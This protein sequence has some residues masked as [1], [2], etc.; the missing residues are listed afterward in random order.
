MTEQTFTP[1]QLAMLAEPLNLDVVKQRKGSFDKE[2]GTY[3]MLAYITGK[4]AID[5]ANRIFG[6]G[7]WGYKVVARGREVVRDDKKGTIEYYSCDVELSVVGAAFP[8][9]GS[10]VGIVTSPYT[11]EMHEKARKEAETD[12]LKRALRHFGGQF[13]NSLY[14]MDD[15]VEAEDGARVQ[16][17]DI[18]VARAQ[19]AGRTNE[20]RVI[21]GSTQ[22]ALPAAAIPKALHKV[23]GAAKQRAFTLGVAKN[24]EEWDALLTAANVTKIR[25]QSDVDAINLELDALEQRR[26]SARVAK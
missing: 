3:K 8:F 6:Y 19:R 20:R 23:V 26:Q 9:P 2:T 24:A 17:K 7:Q 12:A 22:K 14:D 25:Y 21:E 15:Y 16:V 13:A 18:T 1:D 5:T 10:G 11:V 4:T